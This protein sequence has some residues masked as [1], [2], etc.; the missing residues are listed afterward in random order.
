MHAVQLAG[1]WLSLGGDRASGVL[2]V[3]P[4]HAWPPGLRTNKYPM[5]AVPPGLCNGSKWPP[6]QH[7]N[8]A[9]MVRRTTCDA[10]SVTRSNIKILRDHRG[11]VAIMPRCA[12]IPS[13]LV[14]PTPHPLGCFVLFH[15]PLSVPP[16]PPTP[17]SPSPIIPNTNPGVPGSLPFPAHHPRILSREFVDLAR[18]AHL[19]FVISAPNHTLR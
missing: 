2:S 16:V 7:R 9:L 15:H 12:A 5:D 10:L 8:V 1:A 19:W 6:H 4:Q 18:S 13:S 17:V 3:D 11:A 14:V